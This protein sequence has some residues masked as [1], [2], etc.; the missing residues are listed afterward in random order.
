MQSKLAI[1]CLALAAIV[2]SSCSRDVE[3]VK[4]DYVEQGD[5]YEKENNFDA[6][7]IEYRNAVQQDPRF[8]EAYRKLATAYLNRGEG[9]SAL[10]AATTAADLLPDV[11]EAQIEA[12]N[13]LLLAG[14][15]DDAK[16]HAE[17][18]LA[19]NPESLVARVLLGNAMAGLKDTDSAIKEFE[20]AIRLDPTQTGSYAS[21][22]TL[23]ASRGDA[24]VAEHTFQQAIT[25]DPKSTAARL[26]LAQF[27]WSA[28]RYKDAEQTMKDALAI[29]PGDQRVNVSLAVFYQYTGRRA[30]AEPYL[31]TAVASSPN[32]VVTILLADY[33]I[34]GNRADDAI[35]LLQGLTTDTRFGAS[36]TIR[37]AAI[38]QL[39][40][41]SGDALRIIDEAL[42][43]DPK[44]AAALAAKSGLL[45]QQGKLEEALKVADAAVAANPKSAEAAF[46][47]GRA[48]VAKGSVD[49]AEKAFEDVIR[50]NPRAA[51]AEVEIARLHLRSG[52]PDALALATKATQADP[53]SLE[54]RLTVARAL[55]QGRDYARAQSALDEL[56]RAAPRAAAPH[57]LLGTL[58]LVRNDKNDPTAARE[59]FNRA[60]AIEPLQLEAMEGLT[61]LDFKAQ[62]QAEAIARLDG[63]AA[64]APNNAGVLILAAGAYSSVKDLPRAEA[65]LVKAIESDPGALPAYT[66]LGRLYLAQNRLDAARAQFEKLVTVQEQPV[67]ALTVLGMIDQMQNRTSDARQAFE[68]ALKLDAHAAVAANNLAWIYAENGGSLDIA[69]Q[70]AQVATTALPDRPEVN[71][72]LGWVYYKKDL[73]PLAITA[74]Q[75]SVELDPKNADAS[76]HLALAYE[77]SGDR[78]EARRM[79]EQY[80]TLD[81]A[82]NRSA[83]AKR[84]LQAL[85]S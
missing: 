83:D 18:V 65:L 73:L 59:E 38:A 82:S 31:K 62:H 77:K 80:L 35:P 74:L 66:M 13:L 50:L 37:L 78:T 7:I 47:R 55:M 52:A 8:A 44:N 81:P 42:K 12:G 64:R 26:A 36:A 46:V 15:F 54:A 75:H 4:R 11:P 70:L 29:A 17:R 60:L 71:D 3:R 41:R 2:S 32:P 67:G 9:S 72:T 1:A 34:A 28:R 39:Q 19:K 85:G 33:Y 21:L 51:A 53:R 10:R 24:D 48:L 30:E 45:R 20:E 68:R 43:A 23:E 56:V 79:L 6:A 22:G 14:K 69:L 84:R 76:Y 57:A 61:T 58:L 5:R 16:A 40:G 63:L 27:Y 49:S 25:I